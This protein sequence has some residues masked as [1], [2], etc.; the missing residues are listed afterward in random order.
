MFAADLKV[1]DRFRVVDTNTPAIYTTVAVKPE[2]DYV[3]GFNHIL[4]Q[5][6]HLSFNDKVIREPK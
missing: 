2:D 4:N 3:V 1:G 5:R 6:I